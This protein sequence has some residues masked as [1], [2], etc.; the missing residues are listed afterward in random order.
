MN[1]IGI[2]YLKS[3]SSCYTCMF[4]ILNWN[5]FE[6]EQRVGDYRLMSGVS[7]QASVVVLLYLFCFLD[8]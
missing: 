3:G 4:V 6:G 8:L 1:T 5:Q 7:G 2:S